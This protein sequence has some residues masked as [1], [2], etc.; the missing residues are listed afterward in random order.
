[1]T[2]ASLLLPTEAYEQATLPL[3]NHVPLYVHFYVLGYFWIRLD[4]IF[5]IVCVFLYFQS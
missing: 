2:S 4:L 5:C 3:F 1:M